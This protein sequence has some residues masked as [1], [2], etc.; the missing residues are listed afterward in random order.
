MLLRFL[1]PVPYKG[2]FKRLRSSKPS[3]KTTEFNEILEFNWFGST[4]LK[5]DSNTENCYVHVRSTQSLWTRKKSILKAL[6]LRFFWEKIAPGTLW[7]HSF[8][9]KYSSIFGV[10][11]LTLLKFLWCFMSCAFLKSLTSQHALK[12]WTSLSTS[13][14]HQPAAEVGPSGQTD[15]AFRK[16][17]EGWMNTWNEWMEILRWLCIF[18]GSWGKWS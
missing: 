7:T 2:R 1:W 3:E 18:C 14:S 4:F 9:A 15:S 16:R 6:W 5:D 12:T 11:E 10:R 8:Q 13:G 17:N